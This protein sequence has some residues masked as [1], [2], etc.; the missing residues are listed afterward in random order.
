MNYK[1]LTK[2]ISIALCIC[3][4]GAFSNGRVYSKIDKTDLTKSLLLKAPEK[5][6]SAPK[7]TREML[8]YITNKIGKEQ[9]IDGITMAYFIPPL[10]KDPCS[11]STFLESE[12]EKR[13]RARKI[14]C[15]GNDAHIFM[16][17]NKTLVAITKQ[18][19]SSGNNR[20]LQR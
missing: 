13:V 5:L 15:F 11:Q 12:L 9:A 20:I 8:S 16:F 2:Y 7:P 14:D 4:I 17:V 19:S 6:Q 10:E 3:G 1:F 18:I